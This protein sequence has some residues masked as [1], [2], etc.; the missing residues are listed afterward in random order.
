M[1]SAEIACSVVSMCIN[2]LQCTLYRIAS[3]FYVFH[4]NRSLESNAINYSEL[5]H[6][7]IQ[8]YLCNVD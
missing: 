5:V 8:F 1:T 2:R 6:C 4:Y 3:A 7:H